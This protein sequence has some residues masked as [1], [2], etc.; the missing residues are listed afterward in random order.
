V[1]VIVMRTVLMDIHDANLAQLRSL[2]YD[3]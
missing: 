1:L 3:N 2:D